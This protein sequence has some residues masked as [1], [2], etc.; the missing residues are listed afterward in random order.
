MGTAHRHVA[1]L[2]VPRTGLAGQVAPIPWV[3][4]EIV[5]ALHR[6]EPV[7][8]I[9]H[10]EATV[11]RARTHLA[12]HDVHENYRL[13]LVPSDRVWLRD[14][15]PTGVMDKQGRISLMNWRFNAWAKYDNF[16]RDQRI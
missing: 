13:H 11:D 1:G 6:H 10:D 3:Y 4:A 14:S 5:R 7:E 8:I 2:A 9:C 16:D 15:A 12:A